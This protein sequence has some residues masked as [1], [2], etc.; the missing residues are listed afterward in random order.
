MERISASQ[1]ERE[2]FYQMPKW[3]FEAP[4]EKLSNDA[5][6]V[7]SLLKDRFEL[8][9]K[10]NWVD[11]EGHIF[12]I[13]TNDQ[14]AEMMS[15]SNKSIIKFKKELKSHGL[16]DD[17]RQ[18]LNK[19]NLIY[20]CQR[21]LEPQG[22]V[23]I[24]HQEMKNLHVKTSNNYTS[25]HEKITPYLTNSINT[26]LNET[27]QNN[28]IDTIVNNGMSEMD[29]FFDNRPLNL[30]TDEKAYEIYQKYNPSKELFFRVLDDVRKS[31]AS[32]TIDNEVG[33]FVKALSNALENSDIKKNGA[34]N[35]ERLKYS[36]P[37]LHD[38]IKGSGMY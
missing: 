36:N 15:M 38:L 25:R 29:L 11:E 26:D 19:P 35:L 1:Y 32:S 37:E 20:L 33:F 17:V 28:E 21:A 27:N 13:Y 9:I 22:R 3:L 14:L 12:L 24:T 7:Y 18:G 10:N 4:F 6:V 5:R 16:M 2:Q 30:L 23:K 8:S 34:G 31:I